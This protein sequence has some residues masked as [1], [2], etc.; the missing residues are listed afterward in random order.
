MKP[1]WQIDESQNSSEAEARARELAAAYLDVFGEP[2]HRTSSQ[3]KVMDDLE[4]KCFFR[5]HLFVP[6]SRGELGQERGAWAEGRRTIYLHLLDQ[7]DLARAGQ[8][9]KP[10]VIKT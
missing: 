1:P 10:K 9:E 8:L 4:A 5:K 6:N 3:R 7:L 2:E